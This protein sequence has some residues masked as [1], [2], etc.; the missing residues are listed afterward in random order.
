VSAKCERW[1]WYVLS[2]YNTHKN[3]KEVFINDPYGCDFEFEDLI[4]VIFDYSSSSHL[5]NLLKQNQN[6]Y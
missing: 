3:H 1:D 4:S 2:M 6:P 5:R